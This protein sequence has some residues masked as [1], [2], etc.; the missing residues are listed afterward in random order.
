MWHLIDYSYFADLGKDDRFE[1]KIQATSC[2]MT[3]LSLRYLCDSRPKRGVQS[4]LYCPVPLTVLP[5]QD[6]K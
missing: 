2:I 6:K 1:K 5:A 3:N 4:Y